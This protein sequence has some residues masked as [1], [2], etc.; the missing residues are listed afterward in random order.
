MTYH[1]PVLLNDSVQSL[2]VNPNGVYVDLTFGGGGH[3]KAFLDALDKGTL[4][5]FDCDED[6]EAKSKEIK[7]NRFRFIRSNYRF[8]RNFVRYFGYSSVDGIFADLGI[9]SHQI[10][11]A[12]R[13]FSFR[14]DAEL[15]MRMNKQQKLTAKHIINQYDENLLVTILKENADL[16]NAAKL[17]KKIVETRKTRTLETTTDI[18]NC[19][20]PFSLPGQEHKLLAKVFQALR[21]EVNG[22]I[23]SLK[24]MLTET[25][26]ILKPEGRLAIITYHSIEDR[27]VKNFIR[28]GNFEGKIEKDIYGN[29]QG[30]PFSS[31]NKKGIV[32]S[33][34]EIKI[35]PRA[36]SARIRVASRN[37]ECRKK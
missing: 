37:G 3:S 10:D 25:T 20:A 31:L 15:D 26:K 4:L 24:Q 36:R 7:D 30:T 29:E 32:P 23:T 16:W 34:E 22:E 19:L 5:S 8:F 9:S 13:G 21:I 11:E 2:I 35:N 28:S 1:N 14:F 17:V 18:A 27:I 6:A 12:D 33:E